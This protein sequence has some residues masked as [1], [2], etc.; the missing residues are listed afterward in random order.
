EA[1]AGGEVFLIAD[2][3]IDILRDVAVDLLRP[4]L[5]ALALPQA[6]AVVEV[7]GIHGA[8]LARRFH[9]L[10][11]RFGGIGGERREDAAGMEPAHAF[12]AEQL[13][14]VHFTEPQLRCDSVAAVRAAQSGANAET[15]FR[16]IEADARVAAQTIE[17]APDD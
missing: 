8:I 14:P 11:H 5:A 15:F 6:G 16:E 17:I 9:R 1:Q 13:F 3:D 10:D 4:L 12:F 7:I 2:H